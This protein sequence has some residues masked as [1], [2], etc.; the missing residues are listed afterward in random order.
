VSLV[1]AAIPATATADEG[2][3][4]PWANKFFVAKDPPAIV[5][6][7]FGTVPKGTTLNYR[8]PITNIYKFP[9]QI[10]GD[11]IV[12]CGCTRVVRYTQRLEPRETGF[13]DVEMDG[14]RWDG[15]KAVT[16][17]VR[18]GGEKYQ[19]TALL[20]V[21]A[22]TRTDVTLNPGQVNFGVVSLGQQPAQALDI[23]YAGD[24]INWQILQVDTT[25]APSVKAGL[26]RL[27]NNRGVVTYRLTV[28][29]KPDANS[30]ILQEQIVL[31][32]NDP[33]APAVAIPVNGVVQAPLSIVQGN[34]VRFDPVPVGQETTRNIMV[35]GNKP[36]KIT[37]IDGEGDGLTAKVVLPV[38]QPIHVVTITFKPSQ[39]GE[40]KRNLVIHTDQKEVTTFTVEATAEAPAKP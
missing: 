36:F 37:K 24:Q 29:L 16:I 9:M 28:S 23:Q 1:I 15:S 6:H 13:V 12:S 11:P 33:S 10:M 31:K 30:G 21:R 27:S 38:A 4:V 5:L 20:Q 3:Y 32:T 26:Q 40:L 25:N 22:F 35:R 18:F 14:R 8:F 19:S 2:V 39:T 7:D 17:Q 34:Q